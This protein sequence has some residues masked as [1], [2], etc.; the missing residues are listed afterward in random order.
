MNQD[1]KG[2]MQGLLMFWGFILAVSTIGALIAMG[3]AKLAM[4]LF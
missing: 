3:L 1:T 4:L 2:L